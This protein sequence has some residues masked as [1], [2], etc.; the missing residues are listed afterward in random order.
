M[1]SEIIGLQDVLYRLQGDKELL[2]ELVQIFLEDTPQRLKD[3]STLITKSSFSDLAD[4]AHSI[5][6]AASNIGANKLWQ[7]FKEMEAAAKQENLIQVTQIFQRASQEFV[8]LQE[9]LPR[10]KSQLVN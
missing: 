6:G 4:V 3:V 1:D 10:L 2:L 9:Y 8:E 5:K 7:S